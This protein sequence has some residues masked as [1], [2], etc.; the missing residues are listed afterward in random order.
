MSQLLYIVNARHK[1][2]TLLMYVHNYSSN[3]KQGPSFVVRRLNIQMSVDIFLTKL[4]L[5]GDT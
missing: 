1:Y 3:G 5:P 2:Y 4:M